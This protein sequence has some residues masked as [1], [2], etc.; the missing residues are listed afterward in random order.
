MEDNKPAPTFDLM[1]FFQKAPAL[2]CVLD[3][4]N[5]ILQPNEAWTRVT[6]HPL[7]QLDGALVDDYVH[8]EDRDPARRT[9]RI[10]LEAQGA[11]VQESRFRCADGKYRWIEWTMR[12]VFDRSLVFCCARA[13][14][15]PRRA[16]ITAARRL[17]T[18][19]RRAPVAMIEVDVDRGITE[20]SSGAERMFG[21]TRSEALGK[22][23]ID[24]LVPES[25]RPQVR[26]ISSSLRDGSSSG[27]RAGIALNLTKSGQLIHCEWHNAPLMD[28]EGKVRALLSIAVD[29]S[30]IQAERARAE[31]SVARF[32]MLMRGSRSGFWDYKPRDPNNPLDLDAP[33]YVSEGLLRIVGVEAK[34][35]PKTLREFN[36]HLHPDDYEMVGREYQSHIHERRAESYIE[37][38]LVHA[39]GLHVWVGATWYAL[40]DDNGGLI[41]FAGSFADITERKL[42]EE[43]QREKLALIERQANAIRELS[44]PI[45]EV[46]EGVLC[47]P[48]IGVVD[49]ARAAE[50][51]HMALSAV[52]SEQARFLIIDLTGVPVLDTSTA[53][54]LLAIA[55]AAGLVGAQTVIT[56][57]QPAVAQTVVTLGVGMGEVKTLRNLK[58]GLRYCVRQKNNK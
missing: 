12:V 9:S 35:I 44:T 47:L 31:E 24:L 50:M 8:P 10:S 1:E 43:D 27:G 57:L 16:T 28:D 36:K 3:M 55:R 20:W 11:L 21:F 42:A 54:R 23:L 38:R 53:D 4:E 40:W 17:E 29:R 18:Y 52:V 46:H 33:M 19:L 49:S 41:R 30:E 7:A 14:E 25:L 45:L 37:Y 32:D 6:G 5:R 39:T 34:D 48:I 26:E 2:M 58:D 56:G 13:I 15:Q 22:H 51:M